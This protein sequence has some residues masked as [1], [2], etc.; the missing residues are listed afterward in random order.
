MST[1]DSDPIAVLNPLTAEAADRLPLAAAESEML[2]QICA[3]FGAPK[4]RPS[5]PRTARRRLRPAIAS[6]VALAVLAVLAVMAAL[7]S[8]RHSDTGPAPA[9]AA[10]LIRFANASPLVLLQAPGWHAWYADEESPQQGEVDFRR[11]DF[12]LRTG[13]PIGAA[14]AL[15]WVGR[16]DARGLLADRASEANV[17]TTVRLLG[18]TALLY[19]Y[20]GGQPGGN[21]FSAIWTSGSRVLEFGGRAVDMAAFKAELTML[22]HVDNTTWLEAMPP[23]VIST[24]DRGEAIRK[25]LRGI[26]L[27]PG[28]DARQIPGSELDRDRYQL[29]AAVTGTVTCEWFAYWSRARRTGDTARVNRAVAAMATASRWPVLRQMSHNGDW[30][31]FLIAYTKAMPSGELDGRSLEQDVNSSLGCTSEWH[32]RMNGP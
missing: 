11:A 25:M 10:E 23:S 5:R 6:G 24:A 19:E 8:N 32:V 26:P 12:S 9:F 18:K 31:Q 28:F 21:A 20:K 15:T 2:A 3:G 16:R 1:I 14:A 17:K 30:P 29:G 4:R 22:H 13:L 7:P 27:P